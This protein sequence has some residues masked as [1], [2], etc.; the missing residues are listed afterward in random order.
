M[1][2]GGKIYPKSDS[3]K[4]IFYLDLISVN[5]NLKA[6]HNIAKSIAIEDSV[7]SSPKIV[8]ACNCAAY[9]TSASE[10]SIEYCPDC[11]N[12]VFNFTRATSCS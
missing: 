2:T 1:P 8:V 9:S 4:D 5:Q 3:Q 6:I 12:A 10:F 11:Y 7:T